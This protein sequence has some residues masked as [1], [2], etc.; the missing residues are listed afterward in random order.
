MIIIE[1][2]KIAKNCR[3][4]WKVIDRDDNNEY[5]MKEDDDL[6]DEVF[7]FSDESEDGSET[8]FE[9]YF[10]KD[11]FFAHEAKFSIHLNVGIQFKGVSFTVK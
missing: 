2:L 6:D 3:Y 5:W 10:R 11:K 4:I 9:F 7:I 8:F 1:T